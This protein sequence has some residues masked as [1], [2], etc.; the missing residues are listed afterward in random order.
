MYNSQA[1]K[2][3]NMNEFPVMRWAAEEES[4]P[5]A[6]PLSKLWFVCGNKWK[7]MAAISS[8]FREDPVLCEAHDRAMRHQR[9]QERPRDTVPLRGALCHVCD[10]AATQAC[11]QRAELFVLVVHGPGARGQQVT[12]ACL[13][14]LLRGEVHSAAHCQL[15]DGL[16]RL[17]LA[18]KQ[19]D[20][21]IKLRHG[22]EERDVKWLSMSSWGG[23]RQTS[24]RGS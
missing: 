5:T 21:G 16:R 24:A 4:R 11:F 14:R 17:I 3:G 2:T 19:E 18:R 8:F 9:V 15:L 20:V 22:A 6:R 13:K 7:P 12:I 23:P 10:E 1:V